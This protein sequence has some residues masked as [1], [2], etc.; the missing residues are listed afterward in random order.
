MMTLIAQ[1]QFLDDLYICDNNDS[2]TKDFSSFLK[3]DFFGYNLVCDFK[4]IN[5]YLEASK[6][7]PFWELLMDKYDNI[8]FNSKLNEEIQMDEFYE[9][10]GEQNIFLIDNG[11]DICDRMMSER[12][13]IFLSIDNISTKWEKFRKCNEGIHLKITNSN[14]IPEEQKLNSWEKISDYCFPINNA[15]IFDRYLLKNKTDQKLENNLFPFL[16]KLSQKNTT[17]KPLKITLITEFEDYECIK[18]SYSKIEN[19]LTD[20]NYNNIIFNIVK[21]V[22]ALYP[23]NFE[24]LHSRFIL[25]NYFHFR[26]DDSFN[27]FKRNGKINNDADLRISFNLSSKHKHFFEKELTDIKMYLEKIINNPDN[28][29]QNLKILYLKD[30]SNSLLN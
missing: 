1:K 10:L 12:G 3:T 24:G 28:P 4:D 2:N 17:K 23:R 11:S 25:T 18:V 13:Y 19:F 5:E 15:I 9:N 27:Y 14:I 30:K 16:S 6:L 21:H 8:F 22:K 29:S 7:N 20:N 26:C